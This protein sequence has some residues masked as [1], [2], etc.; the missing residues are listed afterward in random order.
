[1]DTIK[2]FVRIDR[3]H[4]PWIDLIILAMALIVIKILIIVI[5]LIF[6]VMLLLFF[7][8]IEHIRLTWWR[9]L[10]KFE[11]VVKLGIL[12]FVFLLDIFY[13]LVN[14]DSVYLFFLR[15]SNFIDRASSVS[16]KIFFERELVAGSSVS[17]P[18]NKNFSLVLYNFIILSLP[19]ILFN[20]DLKLWTQIVVCEICF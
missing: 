13:Q 8:S 5:L 4:L 17:T 7:T 14:L 11:F 3:K 9:C 2:P 19:I 16:C 18:L 12:F 20:F 15:T 1:M 10:L 6:M